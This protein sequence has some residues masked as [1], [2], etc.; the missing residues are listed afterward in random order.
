MLAFTDP[1]DTTTFIPAQKGSDKPVSCDRA[2]TTSASR[3]TPANAPKCAI[4]ELFSGSHVPTQAEGLDPVL[5]LM[6]KHNKILSVTRRGT[7]TM[8]AT[9]LRLDQLCAGEFLYAYTWDKNWWS[10]VLA[11]YPVQDV[12]FNAREEVLARIDDVL[13]YI[14][15]RQPYGFWYPTK[16]NGKNEKVSLANFLAA[17]MKNGNWWSAFLEIACGDCVTPKMFRA[18]LGPNVCQ[19]L[20]KILEKVWFK[21]D[22]ATMLKFYKGVAD[23]KRWHKENAAA[24]VARCTENN[25]HLSSFC[26]MLERVAQ[27]NEE[28]GCVGP[29][30]I[31]PWAN[32][33]CVLKDWLKN[34][35]GVLI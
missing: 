13:G 10:R 4:D 30:F 2:I 19:I 16:R 8:E 3:K 21:R 17:P 18:S 29:T 15:E 1:A 33:W 32:R 5:A 25:Y 35:H 14:E 7:K 11:S 23:L 6:E 9:F 12:K 24:L 20:D 28:T 27:C 34:V 22:F 31:G 26:T